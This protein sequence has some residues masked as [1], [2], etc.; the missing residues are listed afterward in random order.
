MTL[1]RRLE[2]LEQRSGGSSEPFV[3]IYRLL[4]LRGEQG[5]ACI[6]AGPTGEAQTLSRSEGET[7]RAFL[8]RTESE[9]KRIHGRLPASWP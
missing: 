2:R 3:A 9:V 8:D 6:G 4:R 5:L 7:E 1:W